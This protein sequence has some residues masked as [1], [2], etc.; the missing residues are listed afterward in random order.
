MAG[1]ASACGGGGGVQAAKTPVSN[2][3]KCCPYPPPLPWLICHTTRTQLARVDKEDPNLQAARDVVAASQQMCL[4]GLAQ[5]GGCA[6]LLIMC[7]ATCGP[8]LWLGYAH[9]G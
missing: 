8:R 1:V 9:I 3:V 4:E 6:V 7:C 5:V 2:R